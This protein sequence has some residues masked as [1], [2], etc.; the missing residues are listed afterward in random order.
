MGYHYL[1]VRP[2]D[3]IIVEN[4]NKN[5][6]YA[7]DMA[8][9]Q[10]E[11][12]LQISHTIDFIVTVQGLMN[13]DAIGY[14]VKVGKAFSEVIT[15]FTGAEERIKTL[16]RRHLELLRAIAVLNKKHWDPAKAAEASGLE[17]KE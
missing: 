11:N 4:V 12:Q 13:K 1:Y 17:W 9:K 6:Q 7:H 8:A 16:E 3:N 14:R 10:E 5:T 15:N 2:A